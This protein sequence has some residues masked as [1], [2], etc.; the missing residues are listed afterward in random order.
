MNIEQTGC[1]EPRDAVS[2]A[3]RGVTGAGSLSRSFGQLTLDEI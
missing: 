2:V 3:C 1:T